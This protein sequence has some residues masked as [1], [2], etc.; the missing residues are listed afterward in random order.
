MSMNPPTNIYIS[1]TYPAKMATNQISKEDVLRNEPNT[2]NFDL[3]LHGFPSLVRWYID[4]R[5]WEANGLDLPLLHTLRPAEQEAVKR[6]HFAADRRMSLSSNLLKYL[7]VHHTCGVPWKDIVIS[8]TAMPEN[9]PYYQFHSPRVE[10]N[11]SHQASLTILAGTI[12]PSQELLQQI[13]PANI[14][15]KFPQLGIDITCINERRNKTPATLHELEEFVCVFSEVFSPTELSTMKNPKSVL[16][17]ARRLGYAKSFTPERKSETGTEFHT[18]QAIIQF[19][20][21]LFYSYWALKEAYLK[22]TGEALLAPWVKTL[23]FKNVFPPDPVHPLPVP[24]PYGLSSKKDHIPS[25]PQNWGPTYPHVVV[26]RN[27][28]LLE[29]VRLELQAFES[30]YII[31]TAAL[32]PQIGPIPST[33]QN[34]GL[35]HLPGFI[36][37]SLPDGQT[38]QKRI[39]ISSKKVVGDMD[40]WKVPAA[41]T[42]PWLPMQEVDIELDVRACAE[43]RC[44]HPVDNNVLSSV[45]VEG[46]E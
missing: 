5:E 29:N 30:D 21:R 42:D 17:Q 44:V 10:F 1:P 7:Y 9:R 33:S 38:E 34:E 22:M 18:T 23:E 19:G 45:H 27:G 43:G 24:K 16:E 11:V 3:V 35:H 36:T 26:T 28:D 14:P 31:A 12:A 4:I 8:R 41:I 15:P 13:S 46:A 25:S 40:P 32:G 39:A 2:D 37:L 20:L 6:Y